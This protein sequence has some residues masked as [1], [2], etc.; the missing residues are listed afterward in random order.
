MSM[1]IIGKRIRLIFTNDRY[2]SLKS[3]DMGTVT[4]ITELPNELEGYRQIWCNW[5][6]GSTLAMLEGLDKYEV[7]G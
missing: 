5:D 2:T 4:D 3:G 1:S 6:N 7:I